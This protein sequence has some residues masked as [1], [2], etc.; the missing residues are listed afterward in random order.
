MAGLSTVYN[1]FQPLTS[2]SGELRL[3][4]G[5]SMSSENSVNVTGEVS[6]EPAWRELADGSEVLQ[7][8]M[9]VARLDSGGH[10]SIPCCCGDG[11]I[12]KLV[13]DVA[14]GQHLAISGH[15]RSRFWMAASGPGSRLEVEVTSA[16]KLR[17]PKST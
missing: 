14:V 9:K 2:L 3:G 7:W 5:S 6:V 17:K 1:V 8:R 10:D 4:E 12:S 16:H 11:K 13:S 15:L